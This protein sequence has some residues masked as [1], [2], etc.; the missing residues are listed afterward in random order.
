MSFLLQKLREHIRKTYQPEVLRDLESRL[1][2]VVEKLESAPAVAVQSVEFYEIGMR[3]QIAVGDVDIYHVAYPSDV[4]F[5]PVELLEVG[6]PF[7]GI[8]DQ[9]EIF[10][11]PPPA[12]PLPDVEE[13]DLVG[14][15]GIQWE[16]AP[17]EGTFLLEHNGGDDYSLSLGRI[18]LE[19]FIAA[20]GKLADLRII[21]DVSELGLIE[22]EGVYVIKSGVVDSSALRF[23]EILKR[24]SGRGLRYIVFSFSESERLEKTLRGILRQYVRVNSD[25]EAKKAVQCLATAA[26][27]LHPTLRSGP[28]SDDVFNRYWE[29]YWELL[30]NM[31]RE[32]NLEFDVQSPGEIET[33]HHRILKAY[34]ATYLKQEKEC[35]NIK[36]ESYSCRGSIV[37]IYADGCKDGKSYIVDVKTSIGANPLD[38]IREV[39]EKYQACGD[40]VAVVMR[41]VVVALFIRAI[42]RMLNMLRSISTEKVVDIWIPSYEENNKLTLLTINDFIQ[43]LKLCKEKN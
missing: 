11:P 16:R 30:E 34:V 12:R 35:K 9:V 15:L 28:A 6:I 42:A 36:V 31:Y 1:G 19:F 22:E 40:I 25:A 13:V 21:K 24:F 43:K 29:F 3:M 4:S 39:I 41:P 26:S 27:G 33:E 2:Q 17:R 37:D 14:A 38:E 7:V 5:H 18:A 8:S 32:A 23:I 10:E 20:T